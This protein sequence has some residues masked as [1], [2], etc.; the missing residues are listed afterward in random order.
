MNKKS[1]TSTWVDPD[2]APVWSATDFA[3]A[4]HRIGE[5]I[6]SKD[7]VKVE[8]QRRV[9]GPGK[10]P[11]KQQLTLR[12]APDVLARWKASGSGWQ[13]RMSEVLAKAA[14]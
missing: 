12:I 6:V 13:T 10:R 2:D 7:E 8:F 11:S 3:T 5:K 14:P 4:E 9:R 1:A